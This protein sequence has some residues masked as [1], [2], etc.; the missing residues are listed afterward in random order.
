MKKLS[1]EKFSRPP[2]GRMRRIDEWIRGGTHPNAVTMGR[3]LEVTTRTVK[4]DIEY[5]RDALQAPIEYDRQRHGYYYAR[6]YDFL[7]S[8]QA[9]EAE[10]FALLVAD[11][12]IAQYHGT[13]FQKP[14]RMAFKKLTGQLD[15]GAKYS[16]ENLGLALSFRP[17]APEDTDLNAFQIITA[18][19]QERRA[20]RFDYRNLGAKN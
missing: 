2:I 12:A 3:D 7:S 19:L 16:L 9:T 5:M 13:P 8:A 18:A 6:P 1:H 10:M 20:L 15:A 17:F 11:K 4:R 14:L